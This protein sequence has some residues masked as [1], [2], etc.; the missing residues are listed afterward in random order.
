MTA[1]LA[2]PCVNGLGRRKKSYPSEHAAKADM[3]RSPR[4]RDR[5]SWPLPYKCYGCHR[6][7]LGHPRDDQ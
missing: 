2:Y 5:S 6:W 4:W 3:K 1:E 7:H